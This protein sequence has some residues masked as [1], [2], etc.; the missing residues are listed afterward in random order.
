MS[1]STTTNKN[2]T[3]RATTPAK[4]KNI[5]K[6]VLAAA[7]RQ[8]EKDA[9]AVADGES[10]DEAAT[11]S[12]ATASKTKAKKP[13]GKKNKHT[14]PTSEVNN[15]LVLWKVHQVREGEAVRH[16]RNAQRAAQNAQQVAPISGP[17]RVLSEFLA[18]LVHAA[19]PQLHTPCLPLSPLCGLCSHCMIGTDES[20]R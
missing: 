6:H 2:R 9:V 17:Q 16:F 13:K 4:K 8:S 19:S 18:T 3:G 5:S 10:D 15:Y 11:D 7:Q 14:K 1:S 12:K 20:V